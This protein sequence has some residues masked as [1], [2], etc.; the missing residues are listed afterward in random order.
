MSGRSAFSP[1]AK[2]RILNRRT[3]AFAGMAVG[4]EIAQA[5]SKPALFAHHGIS[6]V[7]LAGFFRG[8]AHFRRAGTRTDQFVWMVPAK[9]PAVRVFDGVHITAMGHV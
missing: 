9:Q 7:Q 2:F 4:G 6:T 5:L 3:A 8:F 1:P